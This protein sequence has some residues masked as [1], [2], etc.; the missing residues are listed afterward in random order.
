[1]NNVCLLCH[2]YYRVLHLSLELMDLVVL[3]YY[4][5][6]TKLALLALI[7]L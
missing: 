6:K 7:V 3:S 5:N 1:M 2:A 4:L